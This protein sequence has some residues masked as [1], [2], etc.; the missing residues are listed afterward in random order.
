M[1]GVAKEFG[2]LPIQLRQFLQRLFQLFLGP[3]QIHGPLLDLLLQ[4][5]L[6]LPKQGKISHIL[7]RNRNPGQKRLEKLGGSVLA[8]GLDPPQGFSTGGQAEALG[9]ARAQLAHFPH[10]LRCLTGP[11]GHPESKP[12]T[13]KSFDQQLAHRVAQSLQLRVGRQLAAQEVDGLKLIRLDQQNALGRFNLLVTSEKSSV[14]LP[15]LHRRRAHRK[16]PGQ[17][18]PNPTEESTTRRNG[19]QVACACRG[20]LHFHLRTAQPEHPRHPLEVALGHKEELRAGLVPGAEV[21]AQ[22]QLQVVDQSERRLDATEAFD[23]R[24]A[25]LCKYPFVK[26]GRRKQKPGND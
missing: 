12:G 14:R 10:D 19:H 23:A 20:Q 5:L 25:R 16:W 8:P 11:L 15:Q 6:V 26:F 21:H 4:L 13:M 24:P 9:F 17:Q 3:L 1:R 2:L 7:E 22:A 18:L